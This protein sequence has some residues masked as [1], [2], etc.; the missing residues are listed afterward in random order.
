M[1]AREPPHTPGKTYA[2]AM[3]LAMN[4]LP[5]PGTRPVSEFPGGR[6]DGGLG[7]G[8]QRDAT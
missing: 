3:G 5:I 6:T 7:N 4:A 2:L 1:I 8:M